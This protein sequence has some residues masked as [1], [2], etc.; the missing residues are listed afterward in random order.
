[1]TLN[2]SIEVIVYLTHAII[3]SV[4]LVVFYLRLKNFN[5]KSI[6]FFQLC[7]LFVSIRWLLESIAGLLMNSLLADLSY[8]LAHLSSLLV[9]PKVILFVIYLNLSTKESPYSI[10]LILL[11]ICMPVNIVISFLPNSLELLSLFNNIMNTIF[12]IFIV[13]G[14]T[15]I[16]RNSPFLYKLE[17]LTFFLCIL[18]LIPIAYLI[19]FLAIWIHVLVYL[20]Q[21]LF[22]LFE[23]IM[24]IILMIE[25][26][27]FYI[28]PL[29]VHRI[30][31]KDN[32]GFPLFDH[33]WSESNIG[34][35][36]FAGFISALQIMSQEVMHVGRLLD[37]KLQEGF[38]IVYY[39][40][41]ITV[42]LAVS[43]S[44]KLLRDCLKNFALDFEE[45]FEY[46]LKTS[47]R[48]KKMYERA[49]LLIDKH[50][51]NFPYG[52]ITS[53][54]QNLLVSSEYG[55]IPL[56]LDNQYNQIFQNEE[57]LGQIKTEMLRSP[58]S[59]HDDFLELYNE[60]KN[61]KE[62]NFDEKTEESIPE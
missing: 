45:Q 27:L 52:I 62:I 46:L 13:Y 4:L 31:V 43:K 51:S 20:S 11:C 3:T 16:W 56:Q 57:D 12:A 6:K 24:I 29:N 26:K 10:P 44:S 9:L 7:I 55:K 18:I 47:C 21:I 48:E 2:W 59:S 49:Y 1:M 50:F 33:D 36:I 61:E 40:K 25:P 5:F 37:I 58:L 35:N 39:S 14:G 23:A 19:S 28:L 38:L 34:E 32:D 22:I 17:A 54:H 53:K 8:F 60:L 42:G 30:V 41:Y 15:I